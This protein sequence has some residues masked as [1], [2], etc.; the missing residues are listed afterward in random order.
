MS[1]T[2][3]SYDATVIGL[4]VCYAMYG[5]I[6]A[7]TVP[8]SARFSVARVS[9]YALCLVRYCA[10]ILC[11]HVAVSGTELVR[12]ILQPAY[13]A[14]LQCRVVP[15]SRVVLLCNI[16][17]RPNIYNATMRYAVLLSSRTAVPE[18][19]DGDVVVVVKERKHAVWR[20][21]GN[22]VHA[23]LRITLQ[24]HSDTL[25]RLVARCTTGRGT[26]L[27]IHAHQPSVP[28]Y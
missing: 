20:R 13:R 21:E 6:L 2:G 25:L 14:M 19:D 8:A 9:A 7:P 24:V 17:Y 26:N 28:R 16:R 12:I 15:T 4:R 27:N 22:N 1:G 23:V 10:T 18:A 5:T 3:L 11:H